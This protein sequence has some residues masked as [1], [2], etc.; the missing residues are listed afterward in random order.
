MLF[1]LSA[2]PTY[3]SYKLD[4]YNLSN[5]SSSMSMQPASNSL[6]SQLAPGSALQS[7]TAAA[8]AA[9]NISFSFS[10]SA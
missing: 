7:L 4:M 8:A 3:L 10:F 6:P 9:A 1:L 5:A 2:N